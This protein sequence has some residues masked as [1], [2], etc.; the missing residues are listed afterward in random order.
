MVLLHNYYILSEDVQSLEVTDVCNVHN[1]EVS[2]A[3]KFKIL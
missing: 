1:H 3:Y 2:K